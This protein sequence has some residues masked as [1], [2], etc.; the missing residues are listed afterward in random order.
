MKGSKDSGCKDAQR[1][2]EAELE[3][4]KRRM[5]FTEPLDV[6]WIPRSDMRISGEVKGSVIYVYD[7]NRKAALRTLRH[8]YLDCLLTRRVVNPLIAMVNTFIKL[9]ERE[10]YQEKEKIVN[11]LSDL[12]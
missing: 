1:A 6:C 8:E 12:I 2:L 5:P 10:I 4:L 3:R 7:Q 9:R 11:V